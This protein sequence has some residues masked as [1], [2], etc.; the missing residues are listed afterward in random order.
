MGGDRPDAALPASDARYRL[1]A[2]SAQEGIWA[3][4]SAGSTL[5]AN[6]AMAGLL[7]VP[8]R[9]LYALGDRGD[10]GDSGDGETSGSDGSHGLSG[11]SADGDLRA[12]L[13]GRAVR[14]PQQY[15]LSYLH[16]RG[17]TRVLRV[18]ASPFPCG[19]GQRSGSLA[20]VSD[21][22]DAR[23]AH[24]AMRRQALYDP[25]TGLPNRALLLDRLQYALEAQA[26][27]TTG[28]GSTAVL[29][30][31]LD[32]FKLVNDSFGHAAG[33]SLLVTTAHRLEECLRPGDTVARLGGDE[34]VMVCPGA[35]EDEVRGVGKRLLAALS[36][37]TTVAGR[38][39]SVSASIGVAT[40]VPAVPSG[41]VRPGTHHA[42]SRRSAGRDAETLLRH[43]D[44]A[45]YRA[46][47]AGRGRISTYHPGLDEESRR[48]LELSTE[49]RQVLQ[50]ALRPGDGPAAS[51]PGSGL[52]LAYQPV[53][54]LATGRLLGVEALTR[55]R[56][57][58]H[59]L[60]PPTDF[61]PLAEQTGLVV[62][63]DRWVLPR[64]C[65][66]A[67]AMRAAGVLPPDAY[68]AVNVSARSLGDF[69][70]EALVRTAADQAGLPYGALVVEVT[71]SGVMDDP[72]NARVL[73]GRLRELGVAVAI[74]D[75][76]TGYSSLAYLR[77]LPVATLKVD[78]GFVTHLSQT[79]DALAIVA[80]ILDLSRALGLS[81]VA[82]G[83]E[84]AED[85][86]LLHGLGCRAGQGFLWSAAVSP[87][88][89]GVMLAALPGGCFQRATATTTTTTT[90]TA[91]AAAMAAS[92]GTPG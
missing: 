52:T 75:F 38:T 82:E 1:I 2:E 37:P 51:D 55:W 81:T 44:V 6:E 87:E 8:L 47:A 65:H 11:A 10:S 70:L 72:D 27:G 88:E 71:E 16:P 64:A 42:S 39:I 33:D 74:D 5:F 15:D 89:L 63:L 24:A 40:A 21:V 68:V 13:R 19:P 79:P 91:A 46:K 31:D 80:A 57:A 60:I 62:E 58:E 85:L 49:L 36:R 18:S 92:D 67:A 22:T 3:I 77:L 23:Q 4:D 66:D 9:Q 48:G 54:E 35:N 43:A 26:T 25:L 28:A 61:V 7:G 14:E 56:D 69:D 86:A 78:R 53:V 83:I 45:M 76:G 12:R 20:M 59:G 17:G 34:F 90:T 32:Q 73:L 41:P 50:E 29:L 30:A 84:T